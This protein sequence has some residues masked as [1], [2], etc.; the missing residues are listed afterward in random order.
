MGRTE[1]NGFRCVVIP[2][3]FDGLGD[4]AK[5]VIPRSVDFYAVPQ[6]TQERVQLLIEQATYNKT[7]FNATQEQFET[8]SRHWDWEVTTIDGVDG[9]PMKI[10]F[11]LPKDNSGPLNALVWFP[12]I[13]A[14]YPIP[15][16]PPWMADYAYITRS[17]RAI[18]VPRYRHLWEQSDGTLPR[19]FTPEG[20]RGLTRILKVLP[21]KLW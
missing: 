21:V 20:G 16:G 19:F 17:G 15:F 14:L 2:E 1:E 5:E 3:E 4:L 13:N 8:E 12:P 18:V 6:A 10:D 9:Q 11:F 7:P